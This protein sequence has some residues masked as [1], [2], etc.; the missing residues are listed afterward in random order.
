MS[1]NERKKKKWQG[2]RKNKER[3]IIDTI[4]ISPQKVLQRCPSQYKEKKQVLCITTLPVCF[5]SLNQTVSTM[6]PISMGKWFDTPLFRAWKPFQNFPINLCQAWTILHNLLSFF[7]HPQQS[8]FSPNQTIISYLKATW[9]F[10]S[11]CLSMK[12]PF[13]PRVFFI[14]CTHK[15][16]NPLS[17]NS[18]LTIWEV[19]SE[20][21]TG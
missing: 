9:L 11:V 19:F 16:S 6:K 7:I 8:K 18:R 14:V 17:L 3:E 4:S 15:N 1:D 5:N 21:K 20:H 2:G 10:S 12:C 13:L